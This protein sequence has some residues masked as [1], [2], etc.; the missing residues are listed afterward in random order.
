[1]PDRV[2]PHFET[3]WRLFKSH[4]SVFVVSMLLLF[5]SWVVLE[6]AVVFLHRLG[7]AVWLV[8]H[9]VWLFLFSGMLVGLHVMALKSVDDEIPRVG[10]LFGSLERG[11]TYL[12]ALS[13]YCLAVSGGLVLLIVPGIYLAV[14]YCLFAQIITDTSASAVLALR[15][16][17]VLAHGNWASLGALFL[18]A[19][20]LN[21]AGMALLG[22]GLV[23]SFPVS[24]LAIAGFY[25]SLQPATV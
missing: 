13:I 6:I 17:A 8:I 7:L 5:L 19:F 18:I 14:R 15:K 23:I 1:M 10:D 20:L 25:R 16:A 24:L 4:A 3:G 11:P 9:L 22:V 21:I 2:T 12:L